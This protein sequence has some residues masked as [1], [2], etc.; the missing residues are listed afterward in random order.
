MPQLVA[1][2]NQ[3]G[4]DLPWYVTNVVE[5]TKDGARVDDDRAFDL[6]T[7]KCEGHFYSNVPV[8]TK[9]PPTLVEGINKFINEDLG[10]F[11]LLKGDETVP[12]NITHSAFFKHVQGSKPLVLHPEGG[13]PVEL[14]SLV[15]KAEFMS[16]DKS[17]LVRKTSELCS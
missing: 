11:I 15:E 10:Q 12:I 16:G 3:H 1:F 9:V 5:R 13:Q 8:G 6:G 2:M 17:H 4:G 14:K 7:T